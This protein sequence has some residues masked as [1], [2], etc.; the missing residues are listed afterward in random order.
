[1]NELAEK[2]AKHQSLTEAEAFD[3]AIKYSRIKKTDFEADDLLEQTFR[4][5]YIKGVETAQKE[6]LDKFNSIL[7][8]NIE[9]RRQIK[10]LTDMNSRLREAILRGGEEEWD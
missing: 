2:W 7:E 1:M 5:G 9:L 10:V 8:E 3:Y 4:E 6:G